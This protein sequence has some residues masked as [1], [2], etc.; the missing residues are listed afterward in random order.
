MARQIY[1]QRLFRAHSIAGDPGVFFTAPDGFVTVVKQ[2][3][4]VIGATAFV[5]SAWVEDDEGGK[6]VWA[7]ASDDITTAPTTWL[8][9]GE[10]VLLPTETLTPVTDL[11]TIAD[12]YCSGFLLKTP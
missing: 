6:L 11:P 4:I 7:H 5:A 10:W 3:S 2:I 1:S 9:Y 12:F 8:W